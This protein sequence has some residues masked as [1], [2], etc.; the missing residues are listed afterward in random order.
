M[1]DRLRDVRT[2]SHERLRFGLSQRYLRFWLLVT[3][4][5]C[6][7]V[8]MVFL[9]NFAIVPTHCWESGDFWLNQDAW[10]APLHVFVLILGL[11]MAWLIA[12]LI[13]ERSSSDR[14]PWSWVTFVPVAALICWMMVALVGAKQMRDRERGFVIEGI[15]VAKTIGNSGAAL[16]NDER[17]RFTEFAIQKACEAGE[18]PH[19][20]LR[21]N[22]DSLM[23][24][25]DRKH[26]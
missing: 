5:L 21:D 4:V 10:I 13:S 14:R 2:G 1:R 20:Y 7:G 11:L 15:D 23:D 18:P 9:N 16:L 8:L 26:R 24:E 19:Q 3:T 22:S 25:F 17:K 12:E 6:V